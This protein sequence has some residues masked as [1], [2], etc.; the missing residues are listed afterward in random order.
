MECAFF[1]N[2]EY[3]IKVSEQET[4]IFATLF[5]IRFVLFLLLCNLIGISDLSTLYQPIL[6]VATIIA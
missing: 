4:A 1:T 5:N 2:T 3:G 6:T